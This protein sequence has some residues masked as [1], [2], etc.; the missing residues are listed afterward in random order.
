MTNKLIEI[1][2]EKLDND[3]LDEYG[4]YVIDKLLFGVLE[5]DINS[6]KYEIYLYDETEYFLVEE[7]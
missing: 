5:I 1:I 6:D 7:C 3:S 2:E 4:N